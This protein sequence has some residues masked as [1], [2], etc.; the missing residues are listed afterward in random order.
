MSTT[1][2]P[3]TILELLNRANDY[4]KQKN[5]ENPRL[6]AE[7]LLSSILRVDRIQLYVQYERIPSE[8]EVKIFRESVRRRVSKEP[9][10]YIIGITEFMG[11][12]FKSTPA[13]LIPRPETEI[14]VEKILDLSKIIDVKH[15]TIWDI[16]TGSG[17]IA[18]SICHYWPAAKLMASDVSEDSL[19]LAKENAEMNEVTNRINF[20]KHD[21]LRDKIDDSMQV[22]IIVSNPPYISRQEFNNLAEEIYAHEPRIALTDEED[23]LIFYRKIF[24]LIENDRKCK[25]I[26][27]ELSGTQTGKIIQL[28]KTLA[29]IDYHVFDD[30]NGIPR[31]LQLKSR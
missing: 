11:L 19:D 10:Q 6:N 7:R 12:N 16:G 27:L 17:C 30:L 23:G 1:H 31:V 15:P 24:S 13:A 2:N 9:L 28:A 21:I 8:S 20:F 26:L 4:F 25:F 3:L 14:L 22:D 18:V 29:N 5:I